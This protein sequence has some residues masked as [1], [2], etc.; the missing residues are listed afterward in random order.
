MR[1]FSIKMN[2]KGNYLALYCSIL[3]ISGI[4]FGSYLYTISNDWLIHICSK[5]FFINIPECSNDFN[6]YI[7]S[8][9]L[10]IVVSLVC[11]TSFIGIIMNGFFI[12][13]KGI[14]I[15]ISL[16]FIFFTYD[17]TLMLF[18]FIIIP[19]LLIELLFVLMITMICSKL[20]LNTFMVSFVVSDNFKPSK[21]IHYLLDYTIVILVLMCLSMAFRVYLIG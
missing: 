16:I 9:S 21:I 13:T 20:S 5:L 4:C 1:F 8:T 15:I 3:L 6:F 14:Q 10:Y 12:F 19:Q 7:I 11:S 17:I 2:D 18:I